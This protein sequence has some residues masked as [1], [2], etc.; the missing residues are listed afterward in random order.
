MKFR[1][2]IFAMF[3]ALLLTDCQHTRKQ[4]VY[5]GVLEGRTIDV[6]ALTGG[7]I[8]RLWVSTGQEV[9]P[10]DTIA[11]NDTS[12]LIL[13][14]VQLQAGLK[15]MDAQKAVLTTNLERAKT[16]VDYVKHE[17]VRIQTL[18]QKHSAPQQ[19]LDNLTNKLEQAEAAFQLARQNFRILSA[20]RD[21][22]RAKID[23]L[24]K[25]I[26]DATILSPARGI[27]VAK[28]FE[29]GEAVP[30]L[31]P[32]VEL[33]QMDTLHVKIYISEKMLPKFRTG[34]KA[35]LRV[36]GLNRSF[37]GKVVWISPKAE[38]TPKTIMTPETRTSLVYAVKIRVPNPEKI[39]KDG[40][41]VEVTLGSF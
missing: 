20:K 23:L 25:K 22:L 11:V 9:A 24:Q 28:Y 18:V 3:V 29:A 35:T 17:L 6:P 37:E 16:N 21:Q 34:Q 4:A 2:L 40:M 26:R 5:T 15:E 36:D 10:G 30:P 8:L 19:K 32:V 13:Q 7:K 38:F 31:G 27:V 12:T 1:I 39:L 41:P 33:V 14:K